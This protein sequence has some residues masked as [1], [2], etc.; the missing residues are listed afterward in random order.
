MAKTLNQAKGIEYEKFVIDKLKSEYDTLWLWKDIPEYVIT[1]NNII[2]N[3]TNSDNMKDIGIDIV[4]KKNRTY[5]F[6]Q[7]KNHDNNICVNDLAGFF[8]F[9]LTHSDSNIEGMI[10]YSHDVSSFIK[11]RI[12]LAQPI[13]SLRYIPFDNGIIFRPNEANYAIRYYQREALNVLSKNENK[14]CVLA[15]P[16]GTGKTYTVSLI[17]KNYCNVVVLSPLKKLTFDVLDNMSIFLGDSYKKILISSDGMRNDEHIVNLLCD[18]NIIGCTYDSVDVLINV[19]AHLKNLIII[20]DE[21]HNLTNNCLTNE[22]NDMYKIINSDNKIIYMSA[23]PKMSVYH[24]AIYKYK[25]QDAISDGFTCSFNITIPTNDIIDNENLNKMLDLLKNVADIDSTN[26]KRGYFLI[27]CL[28]F[29]NNKKCIVYVTTVKNAKLFENV[30]VGIMKLLNTNFEICTITNKT[31]KKKREEY[32]YRFKHN[33]I[34]TI[35]INV[36]ILDEGIDIPECDSVYITQPN[37]NIDN[38]IQRLCRC[39]R[40]TRTKKNVIC[41]YGHLTIKLKIY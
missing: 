34:L 6:I 3:G 15:M 9:M 5:T 7:C 28:L 11:K 37:D 32:I 2:I 24:N 38:L 26:I 14:K 18:K 36:H 35:M 8:F 29:N 16:C 27:R 17:A 13:I 21:F 23:T 39:N 10:C 40:I 33:E 41:I 19:I 30:I 1:D 20:V 4:A 12:K 25:W 31:T 22:N